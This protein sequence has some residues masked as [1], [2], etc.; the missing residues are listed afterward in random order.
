[1]LRYVEVRY[2]TLETSDKNGLPTV[3]EIKVLKVL[4]INKLKN[5]KEFQYQA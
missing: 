3:I 5:I 2:G 4:K 1:M